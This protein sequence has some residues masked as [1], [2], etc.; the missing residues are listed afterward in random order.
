[1]PG[2]ADQKFKILERDFTLDSGELT[3]SCKLK[4]NVVYGNYAEE[5]EKLYGGVA[6]L[7]SMA[8]A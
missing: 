1:M 3:P 6:A 8:S 4:R 2:R 5:F 7:S